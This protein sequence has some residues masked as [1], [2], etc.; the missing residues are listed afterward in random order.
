[1]VPTTTLPNSNGEGFT[2]TAPEPE[3]AN[4]FEL[5]RPMQPADSSNAKRA[6]A[7]ARPRRD[8]VRRRR[9]GLKHRPPRD[10]SRVRGSPIGGHCRLGQLCKTTGRRYMSRTGM[11]ACPPGQVFPG[12]RVEAGLRR[13]FFDHFDANALSSFDVFSPCPRGERGHEPKG[14]RR[15]PG[16]SPRFRCCSSRRP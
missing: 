10:V 16:L 4:G 8:V 12:P 5:V 3:G 9:A 6:A 15:S 7:T 13:V 11:R 14:S 2:L 1:V